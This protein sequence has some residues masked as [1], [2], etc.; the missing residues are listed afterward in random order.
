M[1]DLLKLLGIKGNP[2]TAYHPQMDGQTEWMNQEL[3]Q[4]L[5]IYVNYQQDD[6]SEWLSLAEFAYDNQ[7]HSATNC[8]PFFV[9]YRRHPN[10]GTNQNLQVKSQSVIELAEQMQG[11]HE[12][13]STVI[14]H[15]QRLMKMQYNKR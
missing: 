2:S 9:N 3:E 14:S 1:R 10:K 11:V 4:Y 13:V 5:K 6:W 15:A 8:S 7:E 12:E